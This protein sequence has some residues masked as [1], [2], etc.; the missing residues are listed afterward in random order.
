[1]YRCPTLLDTHVFPC[2][3]CQQIPEQDEDLDL[4]L[5]V[6]GSNTERRM[7]RIL[8][9]LYHSLVHRDNNGKTERELDRHI[10]HYA[11]HKQLREMLEMS[12]EFTK[13]E[14]YRVVRKIRKLIGSSRVRETVSSCP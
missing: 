11:K 8:T 10:M 1:M 14:D 5:L 4:F 2:K 3:M 12:S 9:G 6:C 13:E 7:F